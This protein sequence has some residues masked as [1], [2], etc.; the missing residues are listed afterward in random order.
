MLCDDALAFPDLR[1]DSWLTIEAFC[2]NDNLLV[3]AGIDWSEF[4]A[5][6]SL[7]I[8]DG[9]VFLYPEDAQGIPGLDGRILIGQV[10]STDG[11]LPTGAVNLIGQNAD[12]S[13][14]AGIRDQ[15]ARATAGRLQRER[16]PR[17]LRPLGRDQPRL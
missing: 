11:S 2:A 4:N 14:L 15:L 5:G 7:S 13:R 1:Y 10:T 8:G 12:G 17:C 6:G 9:G 16:H 3:E